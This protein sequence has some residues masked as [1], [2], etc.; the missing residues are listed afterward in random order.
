MNN[1]DLIKKMNVQSQY[2]NIYSKQGKSFC[3]KGIPISSNQKQAIHYFE[4]NEGFKFKK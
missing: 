2:I 4:L 3:C 1:I